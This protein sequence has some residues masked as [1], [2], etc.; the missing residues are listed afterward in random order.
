MILLALILSVVSSTSPRFSS[1]KTLYSPLINTYHHQYS[2]NLSI[3]T[4]PQTLQLILGLQTSY[5]WV[6]SSPCPCISKYSP[7]TSQ[8]HTSSGE[9]LT[10]SYEI[11]SIDSKISSDTLSIN[12][13]TLEN[14]QFL[15]SFKQTE[16][17]HLRSSGVLGMGIRQHPEDFPTVLDTL[18]QQG[19]I[20]EK[21]FSL[22]LAPKGS[23]EESFVTF[24]GYDQ[25]LCKGKEGVSVEADT[26]G[27]F[28]KVEIG[29]VEYGGVYYDMNPEVLVD[30]GTSMLYVDKRVAKKIKKY[31]KSLYKC[32]LDKDFFCEI[33]LNDLETLSPLSIGLGGHTF[34]IPPTN[35]LSCEGSTCKVNISSLPSNT[36]ILGIPFLLSF[37]S[38]FNPQSSSILLFLPIQP[39]P[40]QSSLYLPTLIFFTSLSSYLL[41][42]FSYKRNPRL[43]SYHRL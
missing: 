11:G 2:L 34:D 26:L 20:D 39:A 32:Y 18:S 33:P 7:S 8:T 24:G 23:S 41:L 40:L 5:T 43:F 16:L 37:Y 15:T 21:V 19:T 9:N 28:W 38:I 29:H 14:F 10:L 22:Y 30:I 35:Y 27:G 25:E 42:F 31:L 17:G 13:K 1:L 36:W 6:Q 12:S 3:G 4:P